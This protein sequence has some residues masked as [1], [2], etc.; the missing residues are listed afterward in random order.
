MKQK[1]SGCCRQH[2]TWKFSIMETVDR[3]HSIGNNTK[4]R[5]WVWLADMVRPHYHVDNK[6]KPCLFPS[7]QKKKKASP[8][9]VKCFGRSYHPVIHQRKPAELS[10][11]S[12]DIVNELSS[13]LV[14]AIT[15]YSPKKSHGA[16]PYTVIRIDTSARNLLGK[17]VWKPD[18]RMAKATKSFLRVSFSH[19]NYHM[20]QSLRRLQCV[21]VHRI[22]F[23]WRPIRRVVKNNS[24][25]D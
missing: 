1:Y 13:A 23:M 7:S 19:Q 9:A 18:R 15:P 12:V 2:K 16:V 3:E 22:L 4:H 14:A 11:R 17:D 20:A 8:Y 5:P 25:Q 10:K 21:V 24:N 6:V